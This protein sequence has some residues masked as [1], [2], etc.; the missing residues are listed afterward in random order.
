VQ[1]ILKKGWGEGRE[2][3]GKEISQAAREKGGIKENGK[4]NKI[5][6]NKGMREGRREKEG[7]KDR[8]ENFCSETRN[9]HEKH[10]LL[11]C[12]IHLLG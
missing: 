12:E 2:E 3:I 10:K 11:S 7:R 6:S 5:R 1:T 4:I 9:N 8:S